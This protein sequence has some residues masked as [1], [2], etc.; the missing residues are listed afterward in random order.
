MLFFHLKRSLSVSIRPLPASLSTQ[1]ALAWWAHAKITHWIKDSNI[2]KL[3][4]SSWKS[5]C[6]RIVR[7][8]RK[9]STCFLLMGMQ[10]GITPMTIS[11]V[12]P[13]NAE[14]RSTSRSSCTLSI[15]TQ[16]TSPYYRNTCSSMS[17]AALF[18]IARNW[19]QP[20][21][22]SHDTFTQFTVPVLRKRKW[23]HFQVNR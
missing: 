1:A 2:N 3:Q 10:T 9:G 7:I 4:W 8:Q 16:R 18:I 15:Y 19:K 23:Q 13:Q 20:R 6:K 12:V 21:C 14:N 17:I 22:S 5:T 11:V